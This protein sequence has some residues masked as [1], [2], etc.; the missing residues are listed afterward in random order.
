MNRKIILLN[1]ALLGLIALLVWQLR[2]RRLGLEAQERAVLLKGAR[3]Q[4][5]L[6]PPPAPPVHPAAPAEYI[7]TVQKMLFSKDRNPNV[8]V[9]VPAPAP[10]PAPPP[11]MPALPTYY[12]QI[13]FGG[14]PVVE[15]RSAATK[16][17]RGYEAGEKIGEFTVIGFDA[18]SVTFEWNGQQIV[19]SLAELKPK[20][21]QAQAQAVAPPPQAPAQQ[22][23]V[24][25][26]GADNP[27]ASPVPSVVGVD[28]GGGFYGC[29][30]DDTS[31]SG[32]IV[33]GYQKTATKGIFGAYTC[34]WEQVK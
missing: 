28:V 22:S 6:A 29:K 13:H 30:P 11:P 20:D 5:I 9:E 2:V 4:T 32:T 31:P 7:D 17:Q 18:D 26:I 24:T 25:A 3:G 16:E 10:P 15:L 1:L 21:A 14:A 23:A 34:R 12:G 8:I 19:R 33:N 27:A